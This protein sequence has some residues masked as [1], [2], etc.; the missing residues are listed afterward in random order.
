MGKDTSA[1]L[2]VKRP[3]IMVDVDKLI[4]AAT[5]VLWET[6]TFP[7]DIQKYFANLKDNQEGD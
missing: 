2:P 7:A 5:H 6:R 4:P 1:A 3:G